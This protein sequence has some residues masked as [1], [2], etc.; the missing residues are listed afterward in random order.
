MRVR[1]GPAV[2]A[3]VVAGTTITLAQ[4]A[5]ADATTTTFTVAAGS[6]GESSPANA[7]LGP[8]VAGESTSAPL[9]T[10]TVTDTRAALDASWTET[11]V[12]TAFTTGGATPAETLPA[13]AVSYWSGPAT[14]TTGAGT[15]TPGQEDAGDAQT[16]DTERDAFSHT[17]S[18]SNSASFAPTLILAVPPAA[19]AGTYTGTVTHSL[20]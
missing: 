12:A 19:V 1:H 13:T 9:G 16:L 8:A 15:F 5:L 20:A 18:G 10:V 4:P 6:I 3:L 14:A 2:I 17:G 7:A 11:V